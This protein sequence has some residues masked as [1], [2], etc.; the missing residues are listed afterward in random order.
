MPAAAAHARHPRAPPFVDPL[1][2]ARH[3]PENT[4]LY[5]LVEQHYPAFRFPARALR[6]LPRRE[7]GGIQLQEARL[8]SVMWCAAHGRDG[9]ASG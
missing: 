8:L 3:R 1:G 2:Y 7:A 9:G 6:A 5:Q 4:L